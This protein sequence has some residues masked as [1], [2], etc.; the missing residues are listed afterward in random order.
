MIGSVIEVAKASDHHSQSTVG[1]MGHMI[2]YESLGCNGQSVQ[3]AYGREYV[4]SNI[5]AR[6]TTMWLSYCIRLLHMSNAY[7][8]VQYSYN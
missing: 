6:T 3:R 8:L 4:S 1:Q 2:G 5:H 7:P